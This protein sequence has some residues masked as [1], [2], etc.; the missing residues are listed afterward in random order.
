MTVMRSAGH[1]DRRPPGSFRPRLRLHVRRA[2]P[3]HRQAVRAPWLLRRGAA[4]DPPVAGVVVPLPAEVFNAE[5]EGLRDDGWLLQERSASDVQGDV[6]RADLFG[7]A[8]LLVVKDA[9]SHDNLGVRLDSHDLG[10]V[11]RD[12]SAA[13]ERDLVTEL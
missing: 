10:N 11:R 2:R 1:T 7:A 4:R 13:S 5:E 12:G 3:A 8:G 6:A 9:P